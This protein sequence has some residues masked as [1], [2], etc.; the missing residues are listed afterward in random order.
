MAID[1][2]IYNNGIK[3]LLSLWEIETLPR[4]YEVYKSMFRDATNR[5]EL[6]GK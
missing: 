3:G 2:N 4:D 1:K 5:R 6:N